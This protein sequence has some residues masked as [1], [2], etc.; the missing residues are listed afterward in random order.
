MSISDRVTIYRCYSPSRKECAEDWHG[1]TYHEDPDT[2]VEMM[3]DRN[4]PTE[5]GP[6][7]WEMQ[8]AHGEWR[9]HVDQ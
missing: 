7:D 1:F 2:L 3:Q 8:V 6:H 9:T 4:L 5:P